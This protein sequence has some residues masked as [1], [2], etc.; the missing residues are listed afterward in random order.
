MIFKRFAALALAVSAPLA[1]SGCLLLPGDFTADMMVKKSGEFSF[2]YKGQIQL[3][4][5]AT[6]LNNNVEGET[7]A[8]FA[9]TCYVD[10]NEEEDKKTKADAEK[11]TKRLAAA[12]ARKN[13]A[14]AAKE[15]GLKDMKSDS[16]S[17]AAGA[18]AQED[19]D[20]P[21]VTTDDA[22]AEGAEASAGDKAD[23]KAGNDAATKAGDAAAKAGDIAAEAAVDAAAYADESGLEERDCTKEEIAEQKKEWDEEQGQKVKREAEQKKILTML[24]GGIDPKDPKTI[25][26]FTKE[27][28]R[29]AAWN[30]VEHLGNGLFKIDYSTTGRLADDF[31]FPVIP[32]YSIGQPMI[33]I[34]RWDNGRLRIE[35]PSFHNDPDVSMMAMV[36][37]GGL[38]GA[39]GG[40]SAK[41]PEPVE[42]KGMFTIRTDA[43]IIANNTEEGPVD[44]GGLQVMRWDIGPSTYGAPMALLKIAK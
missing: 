2:A 23:D 40:G 44:E 36:G 22:K 42:V 19:Y 30:K 9:A 24:L 17:T 41:A 16:K 18:T 10:P 5:L 12:E 3:V 1:L 33:H 32:R 26:R 14:D 37:G 11:K 13:K 25:T 28:E 39:M 6:L 31:A 34:T 35:A 20:E 15:A 4:G 21:Q 29:L 27:V 8:E 7:P 38:M 43:S